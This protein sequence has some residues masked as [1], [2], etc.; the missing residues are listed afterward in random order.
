MNQKPQLIFLSS[1]NNPTGNTFSTEKILKIINLAK[2]NS[3]LVVVDEAYQPFCSKKGFLS[4]I[5]DYKN[6][7]I[8]RTLSKIGLAGLRVGYLIADEEIVKEINK[9]RLP[10]NVDSLSQY[11]AEKTL[12]SFYP[13]IQNYIKEIKK[14]R[15][16][17]LKELSKI[18]KIKVYPS[19]A[20]FILFKVKDADKISSQL[21]KRGIVLRN[22]SLII[23]DALRVTV[24][25]RQEN[26]EFL[27]AL[28]E[29]LK[30]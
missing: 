22:L 19:E 17:L 12:N 29:I 27:K 28:R 10:Y 24:G 8:L 15:S 20:N 1:P 25:T 11:I 6:L 13:K 7:V 21:I 2:N 4:F 23:K 18:D 5:K 26:D 16:R 3:C 9:V 14:E 30:V